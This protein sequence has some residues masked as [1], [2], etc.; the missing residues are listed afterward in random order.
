MREIIAHPW[1]ERAVVDDDQLGCDGSRCWIEKRIWRSEEKSSA[2][3]IRGLG[4]VEGE[5]ADVG[6]G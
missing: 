3:G 2:E 6:P 5:R 1:K 4:V